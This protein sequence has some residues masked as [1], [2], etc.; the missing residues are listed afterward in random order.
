MAIDLL[1][2]ALLVGGL[3]LGILPGLAVLALTVVIAPVTA[4]ER[5]SIAAAFRRSVTLVR[6]SFWPVFCLTVGMWV[7]LVAV[8]SVAIFAAGAL[9]GDS[10]WGHWVGALLGNL[11][12]A[13]ITA[14]IAHQCT[15]S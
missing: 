6:P 14:A 10:V 9:T 12:I 15:S 2:T 7:S 13:P 5:P 8:T 11:A 3:A 4:L 1:G